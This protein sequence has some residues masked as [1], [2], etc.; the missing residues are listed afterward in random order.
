MHAGTWPF[1]KFLVFI[2]GSRSKR[3][4]VALG[5]LTLNTFMPLDVLN[6]GR[7]CILAPMLC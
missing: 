4:Y 2:D 7:V 3:L 6:F 5:V 1:V